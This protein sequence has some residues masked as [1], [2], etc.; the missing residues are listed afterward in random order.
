V[1]QSQ[2]SLEHMND[3]TLSI[4]GNLLSISEPGGLFNTVD[5]SETNNHDL[6][7]YP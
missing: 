5:L 4:L 7:V 6:E 1:L 2:V 3:Q